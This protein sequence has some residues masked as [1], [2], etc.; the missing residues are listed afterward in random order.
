[1]SLSFILSS[2]VPTLSFIFNTQELVLIGSEA[3]NIAT[4]VAIN[5]QDGSV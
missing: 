2:V 5:L 1:M 3:V 4:V